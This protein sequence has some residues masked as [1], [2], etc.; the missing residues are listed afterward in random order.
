MK[1]GLVGLMALFLFFSVVGSSAHAGGHGV[2]ARGTSDYFSDE[3]G[4]LEPSDSDEAPKR[5]PGTPHP[6]A[7]RLK[8]RIPVKRYP[9]PAAIGGYHNENKQ[10]VVVAKKGV[11][12][13]EEQKE[14]MKKRAQEWLKKNFASEFLDPM[15]ARLPR[16]KRWAAITIDKSTKDVSEGIQFAEILEYLKKEYSPGTDT[17]EWDGRDSADSFRV[18]DL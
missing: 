12:M 17:I 14:I 16:A 8:I 6:D 15:N 4:A 1:S 3:E 5:I 13:D 11:V 7:V 18:L 10:I 2:R 9:L